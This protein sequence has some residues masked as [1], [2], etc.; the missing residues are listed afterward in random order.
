MIQEMELVDVV[1]DNRVLGFY[2]VY[3]IPKCEE[4]IVVDGVRF[5]VSSVEWNIRMYVETTCKLFL[6][7]Q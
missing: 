6:M 2:K 3:Q 5:K 4:I 7:R 1:N